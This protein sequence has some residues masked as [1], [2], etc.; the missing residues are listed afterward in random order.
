MA[1]SRD[2]LHGREHGILAFSYRDEHDVWPCERPRHYT[3]VTTGAARSAVAL[4]DG[5]PIL[6]QNAFKTAVQLELQFG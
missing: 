4:L 3:H 6:E 2:R 1:H 5:E